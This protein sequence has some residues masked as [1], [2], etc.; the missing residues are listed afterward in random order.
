MEKVKPEETATPKAPSPK[1]RRPAILL[2]ISAV[3][4]F[5]VLAL[6]LGLGLGLGLHH[7]SSSSSSNATSTSSPPG[8]SSPLPNVGNITAAE[9]WRLNTSQYSLN[10]NWDLNAAPTTRL[11]NLVISE[12]VGWPDGE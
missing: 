10:R 8:S 5:C 3:V 2:V 12:G 7:D 6:A 11:F 4:V 1:G 9:D